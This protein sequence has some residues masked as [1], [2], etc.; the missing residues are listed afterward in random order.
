MY[1]LGVSTS[2]IYKANIMATV[3]ESI[4]ESLIGTTEVPHLSREGRANFMKHAKSDENGELYMGSEEFIDAIAPAEE[5]Y[6]SS[7]SIA[8]YPVVPNLTSFHLLGT[9][10]CTVTD[11][12]LS[13]STR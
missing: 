13:R 6:V 4:K 10:P 5:D 2:H 12:S 1:F 9:C 11:R 7:A 8:A 3:T